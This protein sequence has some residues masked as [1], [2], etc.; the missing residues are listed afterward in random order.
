MPKP[1]RF[2]VQLNFKI[3]RATWDAVTA[4]A[5]S[6]QRISKE[7]IAEFKKNI[8]EHGFPLFFQSLFPD[9]KMPVPKA[10][11]PSIPAPE[12]APSAPDNAPAEK[13]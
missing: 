11:N 4:N 9:A 8:D 10:L 12:S 2:A 6:L 1:F 13:K 5:A 3:E 7:R